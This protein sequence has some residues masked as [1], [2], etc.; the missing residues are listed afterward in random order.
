MKIYKY[1]ISPDSS[2]MMPVGAKVLCVGVQRD[3]TYLWAMVDP[4]A[5]GEERHFRAIPTG[6]QF[7]PTG[8]EYVGTFHGVE[9]WTVFHLFEVKG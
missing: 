8:M 9:G 7:D 6:Q 5:P 3:E 2:I 4:D 1:L